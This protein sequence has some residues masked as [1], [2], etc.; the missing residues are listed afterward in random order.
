M[1]DLERLEH[2]ENDD[3]GR[4]LEGELGQGR[5]YSTRDIE[6]IPSQNIH[7]RISSF[8]TGYFKIFGILPIIK[9]T[10]LRDRFRKC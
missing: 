6:V 9:G 4:E 5:R 3:V 2:V 1:A 10:V 8:D 7:E